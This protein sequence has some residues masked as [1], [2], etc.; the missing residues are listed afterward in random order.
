MIIRCIPMGIFSW[1]FRLEG[2]G[3]SASLRLD[4]F[5]EQGV[6][7]ADDIEFEVKKHGVLSGRWT[8]E[9]AG[10][11]V[12]SAQK[13][14]PFTRTFDIQT[15]GGSLVLRAESAF[16]RDFRLEHSGELLATIS[17]DHLFTRRATIETLANDLD[18]PTI[19]FSFWLAALTWRRRRRNNS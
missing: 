11:Q 9:R 1:A 5:V 6:I 2:E 17:P 15:P 7:V 16:L 3:H 13:C 19:C 8:L 18:L 4:S 10:Q 12:A 14:D